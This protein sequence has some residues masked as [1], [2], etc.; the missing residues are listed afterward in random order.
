M[1]TQDRFGDVVTG[2]TPL[3]R[4]VEPEDQLGLGEDR[5]HVAQCSLRPNAVSGRPAV[6]AISLLRVAP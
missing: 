1:E 2:A 4:I 3:R 5:E 6:A